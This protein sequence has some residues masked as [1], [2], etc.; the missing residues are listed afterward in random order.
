MVLNWQIRKATDMSVSP[1]FFTVFMARSGSKLLRSLL[2]Q[3]PEI[4]DLGEC[5]HDR[6][7]NFGDDADFAASLEEI[8]ERAPTIKGVQFRYP[9]HFIEFPEVVDFM[10][11]HSE[12]LKIVML[13]R[14]NKF[15][16]ALSQQNSERLKKTTGKAHLFK[17]SK[18]SLDPLKLDVARAMT[19][20]IDRE[21]LDEQRMVWAAE[22][23]E[24]LEVFY[25][26]LVSEQKE[27][28]D[29]IIKFLGLAPLA[30]ELSESDLVKVT[31]TKI[32]DAIQN[33]QELRD[34]VSRAGLA[35]LIDLSPDYFINSVAQGIGEN[36][37]VR[38]TRRNRKVWEGGLTLSGGQKFTLSAERLPVKTN[39]IFLEQ[40]Y[41][42]SEG[43]S[44]SIGQSGA[45]III[46]EPSG[47]TTS[48]IDIGT[49]VRK[50]FTSASGHH[51]LQENSGDIHRYDPS[52]QFVGT[53]KTGQFPWH[54]SCSIGQS[55]GSGVIIWAEYPYAADEIKVWRSEDDGCT[56][57]VCFVE[58]GAGEDP[59][60]GNIRHF[61]TV[62]PCST[63]EGRWY[64][65]SGDTR[66]QCRVWVSDD[67]GLSWRELSELSYEGDLP[68]ALNILDRKK[69]L[70]F[71]GYIQL[72]DR[73]IWV[74]DDAL[75]G[76]GARLCWILK[77][78]LSTVHVAPDSCGSNEY[79]SIVKV[80]DEIGIA[81]SEAK[82]QLDAATVAIINL[83]QCRIEGVLPIIN[84]RKTKSNFT[85]GIA[86]QFALNDGTFYTQSDNIVL[87][88]S[89]KITKWQ[90]AT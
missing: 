6:K 89:S 84:Q 55:P 25:E 78:D 68:E 44:Y 7:K 2:N 72:T 77:D 28:V 80:S 27:T 20:T 37:W 47:K 90:A 4:N 5:Y 61:H 15:K 53:A 34:A 9:R 67:D 48:R 38:H 71:A 75:N 11:A 29:G 3:H 32:G 85:N 12:R 66:D 76:L 21:R 36:P 13:K 19:E 26:D 51:L 87:S 73:I 63:Y 14:R 8:A 18:E 42:P 69:L 65:S 64:L 43:Q 33:P 31:P 35:P 22:R 79:R 74:T 50:C 39:T 70:R 52:W 24:T 62:Q 17:T 56:W 58:M 82:L 81:I 57:S 49:E 54:A 10:E 88:P 59:K 46:F 1:L 16:G 23:F 41:A 86:A 83:K 40:V 60:G 45:E 30:G